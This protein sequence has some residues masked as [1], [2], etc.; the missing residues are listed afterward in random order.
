MAQVK[1]TFLGTWP[2]AELRK[3]EKGLREG[4]KEDLRGVV[5]ITVEWV[6]DPNKIRLVHSHFVRE[7]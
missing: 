2:P 1:I 6:G 4:L 5:H 3:A 7:D